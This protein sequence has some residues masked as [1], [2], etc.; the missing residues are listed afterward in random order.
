VH[1]CILQYLT[2]FVNTALRGILSQMELVI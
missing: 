1:G 2:L